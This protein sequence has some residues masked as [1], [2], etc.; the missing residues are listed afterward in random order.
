MGFTC[1]Q[2]LVFFESSFVAGA[3]AT[4]TLRGRLAAAARSAGAKALEQL[5]TLLTPDT[6]LRWR[7]VPVS[8]LRPIETE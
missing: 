8:P 6:L 5:D 2:D 4:P 3:F 7:P 1:S